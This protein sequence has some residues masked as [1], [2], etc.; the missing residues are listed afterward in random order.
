VGGPEPGRRIVSTQSDEVSRQG[1]LSERA[2]DAQL[3]ASA[4]GARLANDPY[5]FACDVRAAD[6]GDPDT[7]TQ[8]FA[9]L[10][11]RLE[12]PQIEF[13][14]LRKFMDTYG[15]ELGFSTAQ[16]AIRAGHDPAVAARFYT[17]RVDETDRRLTDAISVLLQGTGG[18][19]RGAPDRRTARQQGRRNQQRGTRAQRTAG[20]ARQSRP[21]DQ[22]PVE[23]FRKSTPGIPG[24]L[25]VFWPRTTL[26]G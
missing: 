19:G 22:A 3:L 17:G 10:R 24:F 9:R 14:S 1:F 16:V 23:P 11:D 8:Y 18:S 26:T 12:L 2:H 5:L 4:A 7:I 25:R 20:A 13:K 6:P 15:Q 21:C